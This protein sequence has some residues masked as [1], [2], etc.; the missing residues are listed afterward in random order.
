[1]IEVKPIRSLDTVMSVPGSKYVANRLLVICSLADGTSVLNNVPDN[2]DINKAIAALKSLGARISK[3]D[4]AVILEGTSGKLR[5]TEIDVG[6]SGTLLRFITGLAAL[7]EG[8]TTVTGSERIQER[9]VADLLDGLKQLGSVSRSDNGFPPVTIEGGILK[10][11]TAKVA[12]GVSSQFVSSLLLV[13]PYALEDVEILVEGGPVSKSYIDMTIDL[14]EEFGVS[15]ER[16]GYEKFKIRSGQR[17]RAKE[18]VVPADF[19]SANYFLAAAAIIP[20]T[21]KV[22]GLDTSQKGEARFADMLEEMGCDV[23]RSEDSIEVTGNDLVGIDVDMSDM[24]DAVLT[25]AAVA[26]F[27][28]GRT[29]IRN[30]GHLRYKESDRLRDTV[31]ELRRVGGRAEAGEDKMV[32]EESHV[33]EA[34]IKPHNDHRIAMSF[35]VIGLKTG[36]KIEDPECVNKS[37]PGFWD[38]IAELYNV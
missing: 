5:G 10:G 33:H 32:V 18:Y 29:T 13:A 34:V 11:G 35:G 26:L 1:M 9:P 28:S 12:G 31:A 23:Y 21:V 24:P 38:R 20:G 25:L 6:E 2:E 17:Y 22:T 14:M 27:A 37:F 36:M 7:A 3:K 8:E 4:G 15:V 16:T 19:S 30:I